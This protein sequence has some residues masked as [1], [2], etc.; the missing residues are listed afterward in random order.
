MKNIQFIINALSYLSRTR[1]MMLRLLFLGIIASFT[2]CSHRL[3]ALNIKNYL[4]KQITIKYITITE[5]LD[6][7]KSFYFIGIPESIGIVVPPGKTIEVEDNVMLYSPYL[8]DEEK[9]EFSKTNSH[10]ASFNNLNIKVEYEGKVHIFNTLAL[11]KKIRNE[12]INNEIGI[13]FKIP[14]DKTKM[15]R[16]YFNTTGKLNELNIRFDLVVKSQ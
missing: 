2:F 9:E 14:V 7:L 16:Y 3:D 8:S 15:S 4:E 6:E 12:L 5:S 13:V 10:T 1:A 11:S